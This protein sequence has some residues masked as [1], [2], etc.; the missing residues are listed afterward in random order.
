MNYFHYF[1]IA[2]FSGIT[3]TNAIPAFDYLVAAK[4]NTH[5]LRLE[6]SM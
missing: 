3:D 2:L 4:Q 6:I 5:Q 1:D